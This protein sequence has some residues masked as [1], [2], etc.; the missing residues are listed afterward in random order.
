MGSGEARAIRPSTTNAQ[1]GNSLDGETRN[2]LDEETR[3]WEGTLK[4]PVPSLLHTV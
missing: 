3:E 4:L 2:S 1:S